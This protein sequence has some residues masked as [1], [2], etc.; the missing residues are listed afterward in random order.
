MK[1]SGFGCIQYI[2]C[3][4]WT[5]FNWKTVR[6]EPHIHGLSGR[7]EGG[8]GR[9]EYARYIVDTNVKKEKS[10]RLR[11]FKIWLNVCARLT[12]ENDT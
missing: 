3:Q 11:F 6:S 10:E 7:G 8:G 5:C 2:S 12:P 9:G 1:V 4:F